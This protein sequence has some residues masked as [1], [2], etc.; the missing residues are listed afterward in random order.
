MVSCR[1]SEFF[2][3]ARAARVVRLAAEGER[4]VHHQMMRGDSALLAER[5]AGGDVVG[6]MATFV[7]AETR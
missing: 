6:A 5:P 4:S 7:G 2:R 3:V 1:D